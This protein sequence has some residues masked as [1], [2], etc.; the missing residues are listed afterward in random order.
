MKA[1]QFVEEPPVFYSIKENDGYVHG[2]TFF[3]VYGRF[4]TPNTQL[5][6]DGIPAKT[7]RFHDSQRVTFQSPGGTLGTKL[8]LSTEL[9]SLNIENAWNYKAIPLFIKNVTPT[10]VKPKVVTGSELL[11]SSF[12]L[13]QMC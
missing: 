6:I 10:S 7:H 5:L 9:G 11:V 2:D 4:F 8:E 3:T 1:I 12:L 13:G